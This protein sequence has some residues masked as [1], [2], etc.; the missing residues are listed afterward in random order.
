MRSNNK[1]VGISRGHPAQDLFCR[2]TAQDGEFGFYLIMPHFIEKFFQFGH[3]LGLNIRFDVVYRKNTTRVEC[4][5]E[6]LFNHMNQIKAC[7]EG[8]SEVKCIAQSRTGI[9]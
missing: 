1:Q 3:Y 2:R 4:R 8:F 6:A 5:M 9:V 7:L